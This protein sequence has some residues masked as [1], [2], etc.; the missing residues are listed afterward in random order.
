LIVL[1]THVWVWWLD[2]PDQIP[3]RARRTITETS[4]ED[5]PVYISSISVWEILM[6]AA[7]GRIEFSMDAQDWITSIGVA[8]FPRAPIHFSAADTRRRTSSKKFKPNVT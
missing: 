2:N 4:R 3:A 8:L 5:T 7:K 6:L 1:D